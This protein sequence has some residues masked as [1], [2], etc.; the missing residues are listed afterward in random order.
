MFAIKHFLEQSTQSSATIVCWSTIEQLHLS[1]FVC[2]SSV[3]P[4]SRVLTRICY[5]RSAPSSINK[6]INSVRKRMAEKRSD[7]FSPRIKYEKKNI[8][9]VCARV[10]FY[11][12]FFISF[13][14]LVETLILS[15]MEMAWATKLKLLE[16][17]ESER[18]EPNTIYTIYI[19]I[20]S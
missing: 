15:A 16:N 17:N 9:L 10:R 8:E 13:H 2:Y 5:N 7:L 20:C 1:R 12:R 11:C 18:E 3:H 19:Y 6:T 4:Y 14:L